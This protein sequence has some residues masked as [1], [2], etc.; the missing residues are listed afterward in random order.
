MNGTYLDHAGLVAVPGGPKQ[1]VA[2][3]FGGGFLGANGGGS[4]T[5]NRWYASLFYDKEKV[6][7][8]TIETGFTVH[9][10]GQY[11]DTYGNTAFINHPR[12]ATDLTPV[13]FNDRKVREW[14]TLDWIMNYSFNVAAPGAQNQVPGYAKDGGKNAKTKDG[15][16]KNVTSVS[17]A[18]YNACGWRAWLNDV[19]L[20]FG[21]NNVFDE[22]PPFVAA[23]FENGY[24][25][26]TT[27]LKGR[28]WYV[29]VKKRF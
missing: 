16:D 4:L 15:K 3:K 5:H 23:A 14:L 17:T 9:Y 8:G 25:E 18:E 10:I 27:N 2:G 26:Q 21:M 1:E 7:G 20:T 29:A 12:S 6:L 22:E 13:G 11:W 28:T 24:D 19:T